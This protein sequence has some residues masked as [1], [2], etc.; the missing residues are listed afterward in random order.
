MQSRSKWIMLS[1]AVLLTASSVA[2]ADTPSAGVATGGMP[3]NTT[4]GM[5][6]GMTGGNAKGGGMMGG[7]MMGMEHHCGATVNGSIIPQLPPGNEKLQL[8]MQ[9]EMMQKMGEILVRY[10]DQIEVRKAGSP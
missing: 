9:G 5:H 3:A 2:A 7:G 10:A 6:H 1:M 8:K 4:M